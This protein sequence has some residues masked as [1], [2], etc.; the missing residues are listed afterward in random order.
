MAE[1]ARR[2]V[3]GRNSSS[4]KERVSLHSVK[5]QATTN[6]LSGAGDLQHEVLHHRLRLGMASALAGAGT[7]TFVELRD[8]LQT[9]DGNLSVHARKLEEAGMVSCT[10]SFA[11]RKP[12]TDYCLTQ[13]GQ[14]ALRRYLDHME[15]LIQ[16][17]RLALGR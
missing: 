6:T 3:V 1:R 5:T 8:L 11:D 17:A 15:A 4:G 9:T 7:L 13:A 14:R 10:K 2:V 16:A 12:R